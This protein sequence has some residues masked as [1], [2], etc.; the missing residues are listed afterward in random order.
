VL[1]ALAVGCFM[2]GPRAFGVLISA[3][4]GL[5]VWELTR[6]IGAKTAQ[7]PVVLGLVAAVTTGL[8]LTTLGYLTP[9]LLLFTMVALHLS[10]IKDRLISM[11]YGL[12]VLLTGAGLLRLTH[13]DPDLVIGIIVVVVVTDV[14]GYFAGKS[15]GGRKFWPSISPKKTWA[16]IAAGWAAAALIA[17]VVTLDVRIALVA[18]GMS[19]ASQLGDIAES[20]IKRRAEV[21]DS[22]NLIPGHGGVLDRFDGIVGATLVLAAVLFVFRFV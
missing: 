2:A 16:G 8:P 5:M 22:S 18:M 3:F 19:F 10:V 13:L 1:I 11:A 15:I 6:M 21:K 14:A 7:L 20:A 12:A 17:L 4:T 9:F